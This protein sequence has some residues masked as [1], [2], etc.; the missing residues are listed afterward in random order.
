MSFAP[1]LAAIS[2]CEVLVAAPSGRFT[3]QLPYHCALF[4]GSGA[5]IAISACG[6][7]GRRDQPDAVLAGVGGVGRVS[8]QPRD[9]RARRC[10]QR[11]RRRCGQRRGRDSAIYYDQEEEQGK[12]GPAKEGQKAPRRGQRAACACSS[13]APRRGRRAACASSSSVAQKPGGQVVLIP[14]APA[15]PGVPGAAPGTSG[16]APG[17]SGG[18][19]AS[20][21]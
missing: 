12:Q 16:A 10:G 7:D 18:S 14:G 13:K 8:W 17:A 3:Q 1:F 15:A 4:L 21:G 9:P 20:C 19:C 6:D 2:A 11:Q 5:P